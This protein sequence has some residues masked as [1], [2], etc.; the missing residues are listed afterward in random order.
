MAVAVAVGAGSGV[1]VGSGASVAV[2][3]ALGVGDG[4]DVGVSGAT[5]GAAHP[6]AISTIRLKRSN[7]FTRNPCPF[8]RFHKPLLQNEIH[9]QERQ[10]VEEG[11]AEFNGLIEAVEDVHRAGRVQIFVGLHE[12]G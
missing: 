8:H 9:Q 6:A 2:A 7:L 5:R 1:A 3:E 11:A 10:D 12:F 4:A